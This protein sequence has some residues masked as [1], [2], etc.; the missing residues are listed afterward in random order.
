M[1]PARIQRAWEVL[2]ATGRGLAAWQEETPPPLLPR[3]EA[4]ALVLVPDPAWL[5]DRIAH[6][7]AR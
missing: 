2:R 1:N 6:R 3:A 7:F 5:N 4:E